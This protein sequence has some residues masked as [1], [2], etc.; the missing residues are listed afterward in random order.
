[1]KSGRTI[2]LALA[3][4]LL[5]VVGSAEAGTFNSTGTYSGTI[6][7]VAVN[8]WSGV[9]VGLT[10]GATCNGHTEVILL[11]TDPHCKDMLAVLMTAET[12][13]KNVRM[14]ALTGTIQ[15]YYTNYAYCVIT[16][17]SLGDFSAW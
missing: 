9:G 8:F 2:V 7:G 11:Y 1:M 4:S 15:T 16:A 13:G 10:G 6:S 17:V 14:Y 3:A 5:G 12:T